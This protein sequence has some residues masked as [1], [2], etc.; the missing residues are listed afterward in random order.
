MLI[1]DVSHELL[2]EVLERHEPGCS[3]V[4]VEH[5]PEVLSLAKHLE[6]ELVAPL[7]RRRVDNG[8]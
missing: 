7:R 6:E 3:A 5:D 8:P 1:A 4:L 2:E